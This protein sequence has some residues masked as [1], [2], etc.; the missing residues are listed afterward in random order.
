MDYTL[1]KIFSTKFLEMKKKNKL[2]NN[3]AT[4]NYLKD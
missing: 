2:I 3:I 1:E 4:I